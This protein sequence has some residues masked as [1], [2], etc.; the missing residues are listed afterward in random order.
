M[1]KPFALVYAVISTLLMT[2]T[3]ISISF[4]A[5]PAIGMTLFTFMFIGFGFMIKSRLRRK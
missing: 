2:A 1:S 5:W 4:G 3:A